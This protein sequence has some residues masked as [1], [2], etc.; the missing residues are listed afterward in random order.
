MIW[1]MSSCWN[2]GKS[3]I[4][5]LVRQSYPWLY[6]LSLVIRNTGCGARGADAV[7]DG[8]DHAGVVIVD[9]VLDGSRPLV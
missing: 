5:I 7:A 9:G 1:R 3:D 4:I 6:R 2:A 8:E